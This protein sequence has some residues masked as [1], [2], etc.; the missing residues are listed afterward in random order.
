MWTTTDKGK[1]GSADAR[2]F[3]RDAV[4]ADV[5]LPRFLAPDDR[6][7]VALSLQN[8]DGAPGD[9]QVK[10]EA[11]GAVMLQQPVDETR[12]LAVAEQRQRPLDEIQRLLGFF[13]FLA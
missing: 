2:L 5:I 10:L 9:Y 7:R 8:V 3:V 13:C 1:V 4:T 12:R 6:G 11:T